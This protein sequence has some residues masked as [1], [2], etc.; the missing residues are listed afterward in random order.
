MVFDTQKLI[1]LVGITKVDGKRNAIAV[2]GAPK[3]AAV[4]P[5]GAG[6]F[7][8]CDELREVIRKEDVVVLSVGDVASARLLE[9]YVPIRIA[10]Q[11]RLG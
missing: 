4:A 6:C 11:R 8:G 2:R 10:A 9:R 5:V 1:Q 7:D 3:R